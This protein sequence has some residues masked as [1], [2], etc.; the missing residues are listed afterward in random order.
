MH[1]CIATSCTIDS[2]PCKVS[3]IA[4]TS[5]WGSIC[6]SKSRHLLRR[7]RATLGSR[8][9]FTV[10]LARGFSRLKGLF[11]TAVA[12]LSTQDPLLRPLTTFYHP[13]GPGNWNSALDTVK[14]TVSVGSK[15][16]PD[17]YVSSVSE[18]FYRLRL[19]TGKSTGD[20]TMSIT[21]QQYRNSRW[22]YGQDFEKAATGLGGGASHTGLSTK[23]C[24][25]LTLDFK[26][27]GPDAAHAPTQTFVHMH[28]DIL[29]NL[30]ISPE[31]TSS[32]RTGTYYDILLN[33]S[34]TKWRGRPPT[35]S[36]LYFEDPQTRVH[37]KPCECRNSYHLRC[38]GISNVSG[39]LSTMAH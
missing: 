39:S 35:R 18:A 1:G 21:P 33:L 4:L 12:D 11:A 31:W 23:G 14:V 22:I 20:E 3:S 36:S 6:P 37:W 32:T 10:V 2:W 30:S 15:R 7:S 38:S 34:I 16:Y 8:T 28:Y 24:E 19:A 17:Y 25:L 13:M 29:L 26:D 27:F 9:S 5:Y